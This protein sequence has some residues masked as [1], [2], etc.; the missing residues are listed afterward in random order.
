MNKTSE[1]E[2]LGLREQDSLLKC[3]RQRVEALADE[4]LL[5]DLKKRALQRR[6]VVAE[7]LIYLGEIDARHLYRLFGNQSMLAFCLIRLRLSEPTACRYLAAARLSRSHPQALRLLEQGKVHVAGLATIARYVDDQ[8]GGE[9]LGL[10]AGKTNRQ[11]QRLLAAR[12]SEPAA[13]PG[14]GELPPDVSRTHYSRI[15]A[16]SAQHYWIQFAATDQFVTQLAHATALLG[17]QVVAGDVAAVLTVA[18]DRLVAQKTKGKFMLT[19]DNPF[20]EATTE[21]EPKRHNAATVMR[22]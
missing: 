8:N 6:E 9:L 2:H 12:F 19:T 4:P 3:I 1:Q 14:I 16:L 21:T 17:R 13:V 11:L 15:N 5:R 18:L 20:F 22:L 7:L 10:A